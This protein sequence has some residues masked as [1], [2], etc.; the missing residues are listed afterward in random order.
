[1]HETLVNGEGYDPQSDEYYSEL[2]KR[3]KLAFPHKFV[4]NDS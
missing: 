4:N 2:D 1:L 3:M